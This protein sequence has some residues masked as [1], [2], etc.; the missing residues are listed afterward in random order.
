MSNE[1]D[2]K[3]LIFVWLT[4]EQD[5]FLKTSPSPKKIKTR[6]IVA[7]RLIRLK[8]PFDMI[9]SI[10]S[11]NSIKTFFNRILVS[12][13]FNFFAFFLSDWIRIYQNGP[14]TCVIMW[15]FDNWKSGIRRY[16][17]STSQ[18]SFQ[19]HVIEEAALNVTRLCGQHDSCQIHKIH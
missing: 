3:M 7:G 4:R 14:S 6:L 18:V 19:R 11:F 17:T 16:G 13:Y 15:G 2:K 9:S 1:K 10:L 8:N 12:C 5:S